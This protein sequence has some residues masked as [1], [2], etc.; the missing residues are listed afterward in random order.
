MPRT[1]STTSKTTR[2][3]KTAKVSEEVSVKSMPTLHLRSLFLGIVVIVI[4]GVIAAI[5]NAD[6][7]LNK[8]IEISTEGTINIP[9]ELPKSGSKTSSPNLRLFNLK[10]EG[11]VRDG[12]TLVGEARLWYFEGDFPVTIED[13]NGNVIFRGPASAQDEWMTDQFVPFQV[14]LD[15]DADPETVGGVIILEKDNP[16]GL[17][18]NAEAVEVPVRFE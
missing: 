6:T 12:F 14:A 13:D 4:M 5:L 2:S 16:S 17:S 7:L 8:R 3:K 1:K 10:P 15:F 11:V 18:E 9:I